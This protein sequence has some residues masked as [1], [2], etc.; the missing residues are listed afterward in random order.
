MVAPRNPLLTARKIADMPEQHHVH[1]FNAN[2]VRQTRSLS[3][4]AGLS[5]I[6]VHLVR[7]GQ[8]HDSTQYHFHHQDEEF[9]YV[10][11][12]C[13]IATIGDKSFEVGPGDFMGFTAP[14]DP[15]ML[16]NPHAEDLVY[17]MGGQRNAFDVCDYPSIKRR[18]YRID[19]Q[20]E[21]VEWDHLQHVPP[22]QPAGR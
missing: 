17:L 16:H 12:G 21:A 5:K 8:G 2:A 20:K 13:G 11:S 3:D 15:H 22:P 7:L 9:L 14:S 4:A 18:M 10:L 6:G 19:G 1:Q